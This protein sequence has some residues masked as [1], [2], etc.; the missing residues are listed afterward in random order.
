MD[1]DKMKQGIIPGIIAGYVFLAYVGAGAGPAGMAEDGTITNAMSS[2][3]IDDIGGMIGSGAFVGFILHIIISAVIGG[4]YTGLFAEKVE[5]GDTLINVAVGGL[6][7]GLIW[8]IVGGNIIMPIVGQQDILQLSIGP[9]LFGH[10]IF[11]HVLAFL[12]VLR[13]KAMGMTDE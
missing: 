7:Y 1:T 2:G 3:M 8:W 12:V 13:D 5:L 6:I 11:G 4:V 10:V 9:S